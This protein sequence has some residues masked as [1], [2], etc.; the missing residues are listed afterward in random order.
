MIVTVSGR[1]M[2]VTPALKTFA[3]EKATRAKSKIAACS[4]AEMKVL[5][6]I[7][8]VLLRPI[9]TELGPPAR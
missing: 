1:H 8:L 6:P 2:E 7:T 3:E 5:L 9:A 4:A